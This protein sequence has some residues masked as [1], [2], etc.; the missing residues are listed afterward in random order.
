M[1]EGGLRAFKLLVW[2]LSFLHEASSQGLGHFS[3]A[4]WVAKWPAILSLGFCPWFGAMVYLG[5]NGK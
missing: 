1:C 4:V 5:R 3:F 2:A